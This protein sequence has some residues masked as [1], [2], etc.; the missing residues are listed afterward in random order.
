MVGSTIHHWG[1]EGLR[2]RNGFEKGETLHAAD[3]LSGQEKGGRVGRND[4]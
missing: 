1:F 4:K 2:F 3:D